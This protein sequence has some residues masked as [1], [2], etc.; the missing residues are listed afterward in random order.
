VLNAA[1]NRGQLAS[2]GSGLAGF[3]RGLAPAAWYRFNTGITVTGAGVS[4][5][6]DQSGNGRDLLQGTD[7]NRP[8]LEADG[9]I[10]FDGVDNFLKC[11]SFTLNQ[12]ET[13]Y[14]LGKQAT[15]TSTDVVWSGDNANGLISQ[16]VSSPTIR[17][18]AGSGVADNGDWTVNTYA[19]V[20]AVI[21]GASS[22]IQVN[23]NTATTG[24]A[25]AQNM[26]GFTLAANA[27]GTGQ[28]SNIQVKEVIL[29]ASA[30]DAGTRARVI[31]YLSQVGQIGV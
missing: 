15:W 7:A 23:N 12:P 30:H 17:L 22:L 3:V 16:V 11:S 19:A 2:T 18:N 26:G 25:G 13:V 6:A 1:I 4:T 21:N 14:L 24:N 31:R 20:V 5:W 27:G 10:L 8:S 28:W 29:Y 9:S